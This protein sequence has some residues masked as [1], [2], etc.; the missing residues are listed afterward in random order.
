MNI[1]LSR[2]TAEFVVASLNRWWDTAG[3]KQYKDMK[4]L[5]ITAD[6]GGSNGY[7]VCLWEAKLQKQVNQENNR[8]AFSA[9]N[10]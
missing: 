8:S 9:G 2:D 1:G 3:C 10:Q 7:R 5:V 6:S 4:R